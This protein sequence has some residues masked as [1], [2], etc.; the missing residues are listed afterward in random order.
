[1]SVWIRPKWL[2]LTNVKSITPPWGDE[3]DQA[4]RLAGLPVVGSLAWSA[5]NT[6]PNGPG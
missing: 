3:D 1:M 5:G 2:G 6:D 4:I